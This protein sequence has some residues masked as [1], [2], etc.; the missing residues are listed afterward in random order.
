MSIKQLLRSTFNL[1]NSEEVCEI[2]SE[3]M[4]LFF[5][6]L[7]MKFSRGKL[8][9]DLVLCIGT[10]EVWQLTDEKFYFESGW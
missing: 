8:A 1:L 4:K 9:H 10:Y 7:F 5:L 3:M 6:K 2:T